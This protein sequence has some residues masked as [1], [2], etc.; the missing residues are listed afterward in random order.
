MQHPQEWVYAV[1]SELQCWH[2]RDCSLKV[3]PP[4]K[5]NR[6]TQGGKWPCQSQSIGISKAVGLCYIL[7]NCITVNTAHCSSHKIYLNLSH[8]SILHPC[9]VSFPIALTQTPFE[10]CTSKA[11]FFLI[12]FQVS[13]N[14]FTM[15]RKQ[16]ILFQVTESVGVQFCRQ[17]RWCYLARHA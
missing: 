9:F 8:F 17:P 11:Y 16:L 15:L 13:W 5:N 14:Q 1:W 7:Y 2:N 10:Q 4:F 12:C 3:S 6:Q